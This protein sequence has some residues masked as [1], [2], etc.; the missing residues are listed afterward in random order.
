MEIAHALLTG[1]SGTCTGSPQGMGAGASRH[2]RC[3][4]SLQGRCRHKHP[5]R[6]AGAP[7]AI[8][9]LTRRVE[10]Q[11]GR[12]GQQTASRLTARRR[13]GL[14]WQAGTALGNPPRSAPPACRCARMQ[15]WRELQRR[16]G[17]R[18]ASMC[19]PAGAPHCLIC[20][21]RRTGPTHSGLRHPALT[22]WGHLPRHRPQGRRRAP[23]RPDKRPSSWTLLECC[24]A[25]RSAL[26]SKIS[27]PQYV[28]RWRHVLRA[29][30][31]VVPGPP[32]WQDSWHSACL[33]VQSP[34]LCLSSAKISPSLHSK[35]RRLIIKGGRHRGRWRKCLLS[36]R[37]RK[38]CRAAKSSHIQI[39]V[40]AGGNTRANVVPAK[41][42]PCITWKLS[43]T[44]WEAWLPSSP[45][46]PRSV[47]LPQPVILRAGPWYNPDKML[48]E[49]GV[50]S[51]QLCGPSPGLHSS[52]FQAGRCRPVAASS[53]HIAQHAPPASACWEWWT[54][55]AGCTYCLQRPPPSFGS[56]SSWQPPL[57]VWPCVLP[58]CSA[59][60][61]EA[62]F[63]RA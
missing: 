50:P 10:L 47:L 13:W 21:H 28:C 44:R 39:A 30:A 27:E 6:P 8:G 17:G 53:S 9:S 36:S 40:A 38:Q 55:P 16:E 49:A 45:A 52:A 24:M 11:E 25:P 22:P 63:E 62:M 19:L 33:C 15:S 23:A 3:R 37:A 31:A 60:T 51:M 4:R 20:A 2:R 34:V 29:V 7:R 46:Q 61:S 59:R 26:A 48:P 43:R 32:P 18:E 42:K 54:P 1:A 41:P 57:L 58:S 5:P 35:I 12:E 14:P 56:A